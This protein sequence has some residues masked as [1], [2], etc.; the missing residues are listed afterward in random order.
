[1]KRRW[2][3]YV[4]FEGG[5]GNQLFQ[6]AAA[7]SSVGLN[8]VRL[9]EV[10]PTPH[11]TLEAVFPGLVR[12]CGTLDQWRL[13]TVFADATGFLRYVHRAL[14][15][16]RT[17]V[18]R[19][20]LKPEGDVDNAYAPRPTPTL[21]P[22][23]FDGY[24]QHPDWY[25]SVLGELVDRLLSFCPPGLV[26]GSSSSS[27][28][29]DV[30]G[31]VVV[32]VRGGDYIGLGWQ[33]ELDYYERALAAT[34]SPSTFQVVTDDPTRGDEVVAALERFSW[35][36]ATPER[37]SDSVGD[38]WVIAGTRGVVMANSTFSWWAAVVGDRLFGPA[39]PGRVVVFPEQWVLGNG[40]ALAQPNWRCVSSTN[41]QQ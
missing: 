22:L 32:V 37:D 30:V 5:L 26:D 1:M 38:F 20:T 39:S 28:G 41:V 14:K 34:G 23:V 18:A 36:R 4:I 10:R 3:A 25:S 15:P 33:L 29:V 6:L 24:F 40:R 2:R 19:Q 17:R 31:D 35:T 9:L 13:G 7:A 12:R 27:E 21:N 16:V 11:A 8:R